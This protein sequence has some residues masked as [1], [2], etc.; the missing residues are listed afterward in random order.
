LILNSKVKEAEDHF[1]ANGQLILVCLGALL[2]Q[3]TWLVGRDQYPILATFG[4]TLYLL[5]CLLGQLYPRLA[6][7]FFYLGFIGLSTSVSTAQW[8]FN[9]HIFYLHH[10]I[11]I[12][13][14]LL[15]T[16]PKT[17]HSEEWPKEFKLYFYLSLWLAV[18]FSISAIIFNYQLKDG[19]IWGYPIVSQILCVLCVSRRP[20]DTT[21]RQ[22]AA[23]A[24]LITLLAIACGCSVNYFLIPNG[25]EEIPKR[26]LFGTLGLNHSNYSLAVMLM[27]VG[28]VI[29]LRG[30]GSWL[31]LVL[32]FGL[33]LAESRGT[34]V[35]TLF[36]FIAYAAIRR[37]NSDTKT[38]RMLKNLL[39]GTVML[40]LMYI[41]SKSLEQTDLGIAVADGYVSY[42]RRWES[43]IDFQ[44]QELNV[45]SR[46]DL[47][48]DYLEYLFRND[49]FLLGT[50]VGRVI[51]NSE[52]T[53]PHNYPVFVLFQGGII[54]LALYIALLKN[55]LNRIPKTPVLITG[56]FILSL[57]E[58][59]VQTVPIDTIFICALW[60]GVLPNLKTTKN[61]IL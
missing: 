5:I 9:Y 53:I 16:W 41:V 36:S 44:S 7:I 20:K 11:F 37:R 58:I 59:T 1:Y 46:N 17:N 35:A 52:N 45:A 34:G 60:L 3:L 50:G 14:T 51:T 32:L 43:F 8:L 55:L 15:F 6:T 56:W 39:V 57:V 2:L 13:V 29:D 22:T 18:N 61:N 28:L 25:D 49:L 12:T 10:L 48:L 19:L 24:A 54:A 31:F 47:I 4:S 27:L 42:L 33:L 23:Y 21:E 26:M 30:A 38:P 40:L